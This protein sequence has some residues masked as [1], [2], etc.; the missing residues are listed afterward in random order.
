M[1][2]MQQPCMSSP[3]QPRTKLCTCANSMKSNVLK[4]SQPPRPA[5]G[6]DIIYLPKVP[7]LQ[8]TIL[9]WLTVTARHAQTASHALPR[10]SGHHP[11]QGLQGLNHRM[12]SCAVFCLLKISM[13]GVY[14][15][16]H[17]DNSRLHTCAITSPKLINMHLKCWSAQVRSSQVHACAPGPLQPHR[18]L[19]CAVAAMFTHDDLPHTLKKDWDGQGHALLGCSELPGTDSSCSVAVAAPAVRTASSNLV[20]RFI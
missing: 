9:C 1:S 15:M 7:N 4:E 8:H 13:H 6:H 3:R 14:K 16:R 18:T 19:Q 5:N 2:T 10:V 20:K 11:G 12:V 17:S